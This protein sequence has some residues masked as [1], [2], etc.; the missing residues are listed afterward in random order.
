M[1]S[2]NNRRY[3]SVEVR[4][5]GID[6]EF[7]P[8]GLRICPL[9]KSTRRIYRDRY[10]YEVC[11]MTPVTCDKNRCAWWDDERQCCGRRY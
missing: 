6:E 9:K 3:N 8:M 1:Y 2:R 11:S 4:K 10:G 5:E 7:I